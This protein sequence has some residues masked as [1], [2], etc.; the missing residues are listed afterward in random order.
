MTQINN[1]CI[2]YRFY[3]MLL[4]DSRFILCFLCCFECV[5]WRPP[6]VFVVCVALNVSFEVILYRIGII[7]LLL[8]YL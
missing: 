6:F 4:T 3:I 1:V 8:F 5:F 2:E 7:Y